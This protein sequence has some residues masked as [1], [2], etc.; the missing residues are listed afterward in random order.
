MK[1]KFQVWLLG[2]QPKK[3]KKKSKGLQRWPFVINMLPHLLCDCCVL[4][5]GVHA[6]LWSLTGAA[7]P[8]WAC[9]LLPVAH[10]WFCFVVWFI[11]LASD[12]KAYGIGQKSKS[13]HGL[14]FE[15]G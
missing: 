13:I 10:G 14:H 2:T 8:W 4:P 3:S 1:N 7:T 11:G 6:N 5:D 15:G 12:T 9:G